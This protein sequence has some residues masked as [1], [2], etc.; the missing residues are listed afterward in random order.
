MLNLLWQYLCWC[1][2]STFWFRVSERG[3]RKP[4][5]LKFRSPAGALDCAPSMGLTQNYRSKLCLSHVITSQPWCC[6]DHQV[7][8]CV[9]PADSPFSISNPSVLCQGKLKVCLLSMCSYSRWSRRYQHAT[10]RVT[11]NVHPSLV[12]SEN[13]LG[14]NAQWLLKAAPHWCD[15]WLLLVTAA[16]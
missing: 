9:K 11:S 16:S 4:I 10:L 12:S 6:I 14:N 5:M 7:R 3:H 1:Q 2:R 15:C 13:P 8:T